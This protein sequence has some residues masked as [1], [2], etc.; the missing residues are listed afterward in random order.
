M[1]MAD[2]T[3]SFTTS[4]GVKSNVSVPTGTLIVDAA[5]LVNVEI[6]QPCGGQGR[7]GRCAIQVRSGEVRRRSTVRLSEVD[8]QQGYAL[9]CQTTIEGNL[10]ILIPTQ[11]TI[12]RH[13]ATDRVASEIG[14]PIDYDF[15]WS[16]PI[17]RVNVTLLP[18]SMEDQ[19]DDWSRLQTALRQ[20]HHLD[21][22]TCS[23]SLLK[24]LGTALREGEWQAT[25][26]YAVEA[27]DDNPK[28]YRLLDVR[29]KLTD[30]DDPLW[31]VAVDIGTTTVSLWLVDLVTGKV[32]AHAAEYN[33]QI[34][35]GEDV[36]SRIVYASKNG[37]GEELQ[38]QVVTTINKLCDAAC[39]RAHTKPREIVKA[40]IAGNSTMIHLLLGLPA[41][42]IRLSP[43]I[44]TVNQ[45]PA[46]TSRDVGFNFSPD[47]LIDCLPGVASYVGADITSGVLSLLD[48][49]DMITLLNDAGTNVKLT[50]IGIDL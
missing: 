5:K 39:K 13:I 10:D 24:Q 16:Q 40:T 48:K 29:P 50:A 19:T 4:T 2:Q 6:G 23:I 45:P 35:R 7:C 8:I 32:K 46:T 33:G 22:V 12:E 38:R 43:F 42:S 44:T 3:V 18:P 41:S 37:G 31:A 1:A 28:L 25:V 47:A 26:I 21:H 34:A 15:K 14:I 30:E 27:L 9:A 17:R 49:T 20:Q 11:E 36:I